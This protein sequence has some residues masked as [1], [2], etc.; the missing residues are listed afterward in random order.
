MPIGW[1]GQLGPKSIPTT[2]TLG[3]KT[4]KLLEMLYVPLTILQVTFWTVMLRCLGDP[5][6]DLAALAKRTAR[7]PP[8]FNPPRLTLNSV[9]G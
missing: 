3:G 8:K 1:N 9:S 4:T 2:E 6:T 5:A 7:L